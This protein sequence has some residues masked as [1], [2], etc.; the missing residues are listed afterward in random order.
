[1]VAIL[2]IFKALH[3]GGRSKLIS[4]KLEEDK[5]RV[6]SGRSRVNGIG[7]SCGH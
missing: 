4:H 3:G 6:M 5:S 1:V 7:I 2:I